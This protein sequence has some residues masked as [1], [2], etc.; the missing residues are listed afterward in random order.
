[1]Q[2]SRSHWTHREPRLA[3]RAILRM[4]TALIFLY[5]LAQLTGCSRTQ[6]KYVTVPPVPIPSS[7]L[8]DCMPPDIPNTMTWGQSVE[9]NED[10]LTVIEQCNADKASIR[11]IE[12]SRTQD[13]S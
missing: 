11:Q 6:T 3:S 5:L 1:M 13:K 2:K 10:L 7:L 9:L 4:T 12:Q 8:S